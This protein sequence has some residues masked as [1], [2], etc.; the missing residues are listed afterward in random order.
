MKKQSDLSRL[1]GY[2]GNHRY[3]TYA[4]WVL[5]AVSAFYHDYDF[6]I[7]GDAIVLIDKQEFSHAVKEFI[8]CMLNGILT[9]K[10]SYEEKCS[11]D[12]VKEEEIFL[13]ANENGQPDWEKIEKFMCS[14]AD[15]SRDTLSRITA[16][17]RYRG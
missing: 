11:A 1:M 12:K 9:R 6:N 5:S 10:Y 7:T 2:A 4:S 17:I 13:P 14:I 8:A 3:F 15:N 16:A